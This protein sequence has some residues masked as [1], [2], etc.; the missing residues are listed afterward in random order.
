[1]LAGV[2]GLE[3]ALLAPP[4]QLQQQQ[5]PGPAWSAAV[6]GK[7][8]IVQQWRWGLLRALHQDPESAAPAALAQHFEALLFGWMR[9]RKAVAGLLAAVDAAGDVPAS[10]A[11]PDAAQRWAAAAEQL[12]GAAGIAPGAAP[13]KPLLWKSGGRPLLP[14]SLGLSEALAQLLALCDATR[15]AALCV[16]VLTG[17]ACL[18]DAICI[19]AC[20]VHSS[21]TELVDPSSPPPPPAAWAPKALPQTTAASRQ[22]WPAPASS[23][24]CS[25]QTAAAGCS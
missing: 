6:A 21:Q 22:R 2:Q 10:G 8:R 4:Q 17:V 1:M 25:T 5:Q 16:Y 18:P 13:P 23:C 19:A 15:C 11:W 7:L 14:R 9:L 20:G 24:R 3:E 12:D